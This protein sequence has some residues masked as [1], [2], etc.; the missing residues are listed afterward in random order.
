MTKVVARADPFHW[1]TALEEK[2]LP[3]TASVN[4]GPPAV[5][6]FGFNVAIAGAGLMVNWALPE[7]TPP[8][9]TVMLT[10]PELAISAAET[11][12]VN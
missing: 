2:P 6:E 5:A 12:A 1:T 8:E 10:V 4:A 7:V 11:G 3:V 9:L